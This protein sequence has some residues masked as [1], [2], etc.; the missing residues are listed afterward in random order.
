M[1]DL[2][3]EEISN[4][5]VEAILADNTFS[6]DDA[7]AKTASLIRVWVKRQDKPRKGKRSKTDQYVQQIGK[8]KHEVTFWKSKLR[9][10][11]SQSDMDSNYDEL[12]SHLSDLGYD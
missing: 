2:T 1:A 12:K 8:L 5:I 6:K 10:H 3:V 11:A 9:Q 4:R 7:K